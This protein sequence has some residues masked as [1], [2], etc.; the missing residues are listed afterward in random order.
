MTSI[1]GLTT[2]GRNTARG[3]I[4]GKTLANAVRPEDGRRGGWVGGWVVCG[5]DG[6]R[7]QRIARV[8]RLPVV[9][10]PIPSGCRAGSMPSPD[11]VRGR[12]LAQRFCRL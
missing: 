9:L 4:P 10:V 7:G 8:T 2:T 12:G 1:L 6:S 5:G 3:A 11:E